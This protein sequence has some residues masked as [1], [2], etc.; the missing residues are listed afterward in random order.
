MTTTEQPQHRP[1]SAA[2][3]PAPRRGTTF[4]TLAVCG[5]IFGMFAI[6]AAVFAMGLAARAVEEARDVGGGAEPAAAAPPTDAVSTLEV[7]LKEFAINPAEV[8]IKAG[9][10]LNVTNDGAVIHN[11]AVDGTATNM[12]NPGQGGTLDLG[13]LSPGTYTM[14]CQVPGHEAAG[15]KGT[16]VIV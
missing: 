1:P 7:S 5:F 16:L 6:V 13:K 14:I 2:D 4:E 12:F 10:V 8:R 15:M 3:A 9:A 11:L